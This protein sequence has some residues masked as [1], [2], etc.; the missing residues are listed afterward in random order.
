MRLCPTPASAD[1]VH[2]R[3]RTRRALISVGSLGGLLGAALAS[4]TVS[5]FG[6]ARTYLAVNVAT[7]PFMLLLPASGPGSRL[8]LFATGSFMVMAGSAMSSIITVTFR[9][10]Y[11]PARLLGRVTAATRFIVS[12]T[13]PLGAVTAGS[14]PTAFGIRIAIPATART[15]QP[16]I[17][18]R[19][20]LPGAAVAPKRIT[21]VH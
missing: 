6:S 17:R 18:G 2:S 14:Q 20:A 10:T 7:A 15:S 3:G 19:I 21:A 12:G 13:I 8:V 5:R 1:A 16:W 4:R 9:S 11:I